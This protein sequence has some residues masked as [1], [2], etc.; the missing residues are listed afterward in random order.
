MEI[1]P[2]IPLDVIIYE[3]FSKFKIESTEIK[4]ERTFSNDYTHILSNYKQ[5]DLSK[6]LYKYGN[7]LL[8]RAFNVITIE[9]IKSYGK[10]IA[11]LCSLNRSI[12][13]YYKPELI[14]LKR[15]IHL[16]SK[17]KISDI[18]SNS[19]LANACFTGWKLPYGNHS[20]EIYDEEVE[21]DIR[22]ILN[23]FPQSIKFNWAQLRCRD[24]MT[25]THAA[26]IN[27]V[28]PAKIVQL[29]IDNGGDPLQPYMLDNQLTNILKDSTVYALI[30]SEKR[31]ILQKFIK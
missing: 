16:L 27:D 6:D 4:H 19:L 13:E 17:Y 3:I 31:S 22:D 5:Y 2:L 21:K 15:M 8:P 23:Y 14:K 9:N 30:S 10:L 18:H 24:Y 29:L 1:L 26:L 20:I 12:Y 11:K 28:I 7:E 25:A